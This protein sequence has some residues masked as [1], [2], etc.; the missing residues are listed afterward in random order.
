MG[1]YALTKNSLKVNNTRYYRSNGVQIADVGEK[2]TNIFTV[3][4]I[5]SQSNIP[6]PKV[7]I[8]YGEAINMT[9][10]FANDISGEV[11]FKGLSVSAFKKKL[12]D[13]E[14]KLVRY[15][16][17]NRDIE[18][19]IES[20]PKLIDSIQGFG[21]D[22][23]V[24]SDIWVV[25]EA[26]IYEK[27]RGDGKL[28]FKSSASGAVKLERETTVVLSPDTVFAYMLKKIDW[29]EKLKKNWAKIKHLDEDPKGL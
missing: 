21:R 6:A 29:E 3:N 26:E 25:V 18:N 8:K 20:S 11:N 4:H 28:S 27:T 10:E 12:T 5:D 7:K 1:A 24:V 16:M 19:G 22:A 2:K 13:G 14:L 17:E 15:F 23:R 9:S